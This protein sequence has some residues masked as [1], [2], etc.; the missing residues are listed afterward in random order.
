M[1]RMQFDKMQREEDKFYLS[2]GSMSLAV[3]FFVIISQICKG[4]YVMASKLLTNLQGI[5]CDAELEENHVLHD[6]NL[7]ACSDGL[8]ISIF[9]SMSNTGDMR[10]TSMAS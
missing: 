6:F 9:S 2:S 3:P 4:A 10:L 7:L 5:Q 8:M 1:G